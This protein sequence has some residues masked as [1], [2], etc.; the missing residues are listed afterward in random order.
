MLANFLSGL[1]TCPYLRTTVW[2]KIKEGRSSARFELCL[3]EQDKF[4]CTVSFQ[5]EAIAGGCR[6]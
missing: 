6:M 3:E 5:T 2:S 4:G 1:A